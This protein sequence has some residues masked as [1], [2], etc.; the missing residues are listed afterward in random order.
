MRLVPSESEEPD[1]LRD[2]QAESPSKL[3]W[4]ACSS[5]AWGWRKAGERQSPG[6]QVANVLTAIFFPVITFYKE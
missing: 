3:P 5:A 6:R 2:L 1:V 4:E